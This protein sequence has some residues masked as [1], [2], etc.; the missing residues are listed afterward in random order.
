[1]ARI[2]IS[3]LVADVDALA[4]HLQSRLGEVPH[5]AGLHTELT[6]WLGEA[7]SLESQREVHTGRLRKV[8]RARFLIES[9]GA[10]L[11]TRAADG[12]R[13][14]FGGKDP[15]LLEFGVRP[16]GGGGSRRRAASP[17]QAP[18]P[19]TPAPQ[20]APAPAGEPGGNQ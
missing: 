19:V 16:R 18:A 7:R 12:L 4:T 2:R 14:H 20:P 10:D 9:R 1:M 15:E 6:T 13:M 5:L 8:N 3:T 17:A 11:R